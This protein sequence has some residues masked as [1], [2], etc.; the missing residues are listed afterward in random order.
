[1]FYNIDKRVGKNVWL[2]KKIANGWDYRL[3]Q[4]KTW[5]VESLHEPD[6]THDDFYFVVSDGNENREVLWHDTVVVPGNEEDEVLRVM[7]YLTSNGFYLDDISEE[8]IVGIPLYRISVVWGDWKHD[9]GWLDSLMEHIGY[10][11]FKEILTEEN[12][13]DCYSADHFFVS[14]SHP[15]LGLLHEVQK[16]FN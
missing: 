15:K 8:R 11:A 5:L 14:K 9:H 3:E 13:S 4:D 10:E 7:N 1:M 2:F 6:E 16:L 12:G